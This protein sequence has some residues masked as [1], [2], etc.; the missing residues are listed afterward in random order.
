M[1]TWLLLFI[2]AGLTV[3][4]WHKTLSQTFMGEGYYY[5]DI[6]Q[7]FISTEYGVNLENLHMADNFARLMFDL[8]FP[9]VRDNFFIYQAFQLITLIALNVTLFYL[10]VFFSKNKTIGFITTLLFLASYTG[11]FEMVGIGNYQRFAQRVPNLIPTL[12]AFIFLARY[13]QD[14]KV[15]YYLFSISLFAL[16][17]F[18]GHFSSFL[19]PLFVIYPL[20][21]TSMQKHKVKALFH[22][23]LIS[24]TF[25]IVNVLLTL[26]DH[27]RPTR[28]VIE[29]I[30]STGIPTLAEQMV[31]QL[32]NMLLPPT[33]IKTVASIAQPYTDTIII[34]SLPIV[35]IYVLGVIV[36][37][38]SSP[39]ALAIY[40]TSLLLI[41]ILLFLNLYLGK[42]D[43]G[44]NMQGYKY[45]FMHVYLAQKTGITEDVRGDRYYF[46]PFLFI[47]ILSAIL[48]WNITK[49]NKSH[50]GKL[51]LILVVGSYVVYNTSLVW[52]SL[53][54]LQPLSR[55]TRNYLDHIH[56]L[57]DNF[58]NDT[59]IATQQ[60]LSWPDPMIRAL[61][62]Y[63]DMQF[64][65][66]RPGWEDEL[67]HNNRN[68]IFV[69]DYDYE[70]NQIID[71]TQRYRNGE[72]NLLPKSY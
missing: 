6:K 59:I 3:V 69:I 62:K 8:L 51:A 63:P 11:L 55:V 47:T 37:K 72:Q 66:F 22:S 57:S 39:R 19:L 70:L 27:L 23:L 53:E 52:R 71:L 18:M 31:L 64:V 15:K 1:K 5:L 67:Q 40:I 46:L 29:F 4:V 34:L 28:N 44:Y 12:L 21:W 43:P 38:K 7:H 56:S 26:Q 36:V 13:L 14:R 58:S 10:T 45:Y 24:S 41:P 9:V 30:Y 42:V 54:K 16:G 25:F 48:L 35:A 61:Y 60:S 32:G 68:N 17:I 65:L 2:I 50:F 33:L 20:I 49:P